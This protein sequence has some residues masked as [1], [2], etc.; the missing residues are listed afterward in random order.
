MPTTVIAGREYNVISHYRRRPQLT[1]KHVTK[2]VG[3]KRV[4]VPEIETKLVLV[5]VQLERVE[6]KDRK[7]SGRQRR[8]A[9]K[10]AKRAVAV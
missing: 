9:R 3:G 2:R 7:V 10:Q 4:R 8:K 1:G 6:R 5:G